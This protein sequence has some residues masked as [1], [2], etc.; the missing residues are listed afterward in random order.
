MAIQKA[1]SLP[2]GIE[3]T[4]AYH[5]VTTLIFWLRDKRAG[6]ELSIYK[7][8][9][10]RKDKQ[11]V[12]SFQCDIKGDDFD[13]FLSTTILDNANMNPIKQ[14]Y[15]YIKTQHIRDID[16]TTNVIDV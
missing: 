2:N 9:D 3:L 8:A 16:Y 5:K 13:K 4:N 6:F 11:S 12:M 14:V 10:A 15:A 7:D 1:I